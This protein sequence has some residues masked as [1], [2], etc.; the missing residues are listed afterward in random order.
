MALS[1]DGILVPPVMDT[2]GLTDASITKRLGHTPLEGEVF[3]DVSGSIFFRYTG[4]AWRR[5]YDVTTLSLAWAAAPD[6]LM[7]G[8]ITRDS[9]GAPTAANLAWPDGATG[10]YVGTPSSTV[11]GAIDSYVVTHIKGGVTVTYT[12][13]AV[14]R[15]TSGAVT[16]RPLIVVS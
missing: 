15:N 10:T 7:S 13:P 3:T 5:F 16:S 2:T 6:V 4:T 11:A 12:Q 14:T 8:T 1:A 9:N